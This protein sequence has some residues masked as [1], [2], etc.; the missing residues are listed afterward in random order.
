VSGRIK[1]LMIVRGRNYYPQDI[2][3][4]AER[5]CSSQVRPGCTAAFTVEQD[6]E[7]KGAGAGDLEV[8]ALVIVASEFSSRAGSS[9]EQEDEAAQAVQAIRQSVA[10]EHGLAVHQVL[11]LKPRTIP[12][13]TSG[14]IRRYECRERYMQQGLAIIPTQSKSGCW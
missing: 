7:K 9:A 13:T 6:V 10:R 5:A 4:S 1:D 2:E 12:K 14:K 3:G 8:G 11:L